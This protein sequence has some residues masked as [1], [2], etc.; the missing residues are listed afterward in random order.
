MPDKIRRR[1][2]HLKIVAKQGIGCR[3]V[4]TACDASPSQRCAVYEWAGIGEPGITA[5]ADMASKLALTA[6]RDR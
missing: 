2:R 3:A 4:S 5:A 6:R 1:A